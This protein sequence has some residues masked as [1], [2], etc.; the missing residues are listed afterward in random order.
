MGATHTVNGASEDAPARVR[1]LANGRGVDVAI[2][3]LGSPVTVRQAFESVRDGGNVVLIGIAAAGVEVPLEITRFVRR[4]ITVAGSYA[5]QGKTSGWR[6]TSGRES[7]LGP[8][9]LGRLA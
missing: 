3:A 7:G 8:G 2:E 5:P 6:S 9:A 4:G 1:E